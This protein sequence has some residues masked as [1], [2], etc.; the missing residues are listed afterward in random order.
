MH[1]SVLCAL[2]TADDFLAFD[3]CY[4]VFSCVRPFLCLFLY[5]LVPSFVSFCSFL[6]LSLCS[7]IR[8]L[9]CLP[10]HG[11]AQAIFQ[12]TLHRHKTKHRKKRQ[13]QKKQDCRGQRGLDPLLAGIRRTCKPTGLPGTQPPSWLV[14]TSGRNPEGLP[15]G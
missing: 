3:R 6:H 9:R 14:S 7:F 11:S 10:E 13:R 4:F 12:R 8:S 2:K 1:G 5:L 15:G